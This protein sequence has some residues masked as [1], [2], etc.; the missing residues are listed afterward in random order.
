MKD[1]KEEPLVSVIIPVY[2]GESY[3]AEAI[4]SVCEQTCS[5]LE[6]I[7]VNDGSTDTSGEIADGFGDPRVRCLHQENRGLSAARNRG[8][9]SAQ[10]RYFAF[11]DADDTWV[12]D[13]LAL[14]IKA[15]EENPGLDMVFGQVDQFFEPDQSRRPVEQKSRKEEKEQNFSN[16]EPGGEAKP[17]TVGAEKSS[18]GEI[19]SKLPGEQSRNSTVMPGYSAGTMLI[20]RDSFFRVGPFAENWKVGQFV[21]WYSRAQELGLKSRQLP[22][23]LMRRRIHSSNMGIYERKSKADYIRILKQALDR[24]RLR[25]YSPIKKS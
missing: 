22:E 18:H 7:V 2:N 15:L 16:S 9:R 20:K 13:K 5:R 17:G 12:R 1:Q 4:H 21:E 23:I 11:L 6:I 3:L 19:Q 25:N 14:Q 24:R 8:I 10:G